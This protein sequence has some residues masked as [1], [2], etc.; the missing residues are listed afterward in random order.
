MSV[1]EETRQL[2]RNVYLFLTQTVLPGIR[3]GER[4]LE[5]GPAHAGSCPLQELS[6]IHI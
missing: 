4:V 6:L 2:R 3:Y 5:I 1:R